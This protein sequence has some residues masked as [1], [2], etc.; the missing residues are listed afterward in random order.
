MPLI[1]WRGHTT[2]FRHRSNDMQEPK[3]PR[4]GPADT[5]GVLDAPATEVEV[6]E[7]ED[8]TELEE[9]LI[10]EITIDGMCGVY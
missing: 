7:S 6:P 2:A 4:P 10:R 1:A 9:L 3:E 8:G 5:V